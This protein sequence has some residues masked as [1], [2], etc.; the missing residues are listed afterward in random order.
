MK[1]IILVSLLSL[2]ASCSSI[3]VERTSP[4][5][6]DLL[7]LATVEERKDITLKANESQSGRVLVGLMSAGPIGA[8]ATANTEDGF[9]HPKAFEYTLLVNTE[10]TKVV[11]S[12]SIAKIG[13]CVEVISPDESKIE[14]LRVVSSESCEESYK[15]TA[16]ADAI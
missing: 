13:N 10:E 4:L 15:K 5:R 7:F 12:R 8:I 1:V 16:H 3:N 11:I 14:L 2:L 9:S 6:F